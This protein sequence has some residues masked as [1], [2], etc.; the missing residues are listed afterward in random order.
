MRA[1]IAK[2]RRN[3][4]IKSRYSRKGGAIKEPINA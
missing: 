3:R 4:R 2:T 1:I